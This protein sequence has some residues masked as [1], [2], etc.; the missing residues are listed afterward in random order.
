M[1][2]ASQLKTQIEAALSQR[3][4]SALTPAP[5]I[6][7]PVESTGN[8][9]LDDLLEGG[10]PVGAISE[11]AGPECSGRTSVALGFL[12]RLTQAGKVCAWIDV[13][14]TLHPES[15]AAAGINLDRLLW[16]RCGSLKKEESRIV[17][18][19]YT[20]AQP[21]Q[22]SGVR[23]AGN[24]PHPRTE[25]RGMAHAIGG[26]LAAKHGYRKDKSIGTP[27]VPNRLLARI[28]KEEQ[29]SSDRQ[30]SRRGDAVLRQTQAIV[31][32]RVDAGAN[33]Y[34]PASMKPWSR[35]DQALR[36]ADLLL[37]AGGFSAV[38]L[39]MA[40]IAEAF[41][42]RVPLAT[43]FR[44]R[45]AAERT[46]CS[47]LLLTQKACAKSSAGIVLEMRAAYPQAEEATLFTGLVH[48][49]EVTRQRFVKEPAKVVPLRKPPQRATAAE[50]A[51][52]TA[53]AGKG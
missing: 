24:S 23:F 53:W 18:A 19:V 5:A 25:G 32:S 7:R 30:P 6:D 47:L 17:R 44:Y 38:V 8:A 26:M 9:A 1:P 31:Q 45:A 11:I 46:R 12:A 22:V 20:D 35:L 10:L 14:D 49:A 51:S 34:R 27:G 48:H 13:S 4:P 36:A 41:A 50:W 39:D 40:G 15:A 2:S 33:P 37:Q 43:W 42:L 3:I 29:V 28:S 21:T 52:N 16:V